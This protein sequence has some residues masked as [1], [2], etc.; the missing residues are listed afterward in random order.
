MKTDLKAFSRAW[1]TAEILN[2]KTMI[3]H[4][5]MCD[6]TFFKQELD[7]PSDIEELTIKF[8]VLT[9]YVEPNYENNYPKELKI[10][11][12][13]ISLKA[14]FGRAYFITIS[15]DKINGYHAVLAEP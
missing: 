9:E 12:D 14:D 8:T 7:T 13:T 10:P 6:Y 5:D 3:K 1:K 15:G 2:D 11:M 4:D